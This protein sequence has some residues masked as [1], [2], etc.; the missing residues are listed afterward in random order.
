MRNLNQLLQKLS[1]QEV[2]ENHTNGISENEAERKQ[3]IIPTTIDVV[4]L[5]PE[6]NQDEKGTAFSS[7]TRVSQSAL[8]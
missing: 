2:H 4:T 3:S 7:T 8:T 6:D 1:F 5:D